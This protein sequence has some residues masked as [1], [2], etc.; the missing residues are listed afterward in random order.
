MLPRRDSR[1]FR[2]AGSWNTGAVGRFTLAASSAES[3]EQRQV[4]SA[5]SALTTQTITVSAAVK[6][7]N[8]AYIRI[9]EVRQVQG[10]IHVL[11]RLNNAAAS[12]GTNHLLGA[13]N[14]SQVSDSVT[15]TAPSLPIRYFQVG[16]SA[17]SDGT[18]TKVESV[19]AFHRQLAG[20]SS[21]VL[22]SRVDAALSDWRDT[23][24]A[25]IIER[26][27]ELYGDSYGKT[28]QG[29]NHWWSA[30]VA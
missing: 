28:S 14:L 3:L 26:A 15:V 6:D 10:E 2:T 22:F 21:E 5:S 30:S 4:L 12:T 16:G 24:E 9:E 8:S 20:R 13:Q 27:D 11:S 1:R 29:W 23:I 18:V 17:P 25:R 7:S 19:S